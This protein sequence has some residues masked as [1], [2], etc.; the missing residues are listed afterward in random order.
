MIQY[1]Q[2]VEG[3]LWLPITVAIILAVM[4]S[5]EPAFDEN[6]GTFIHRCGLFL[7]LAFLL[8]P[9]MF[10]VLCMFAGIVLLAWKTYWWLRHGAW[11]PM[12][13]SDVLYVLDVRPW[14]TTGWAGID[15]VISDVLAWNALPFLLIGL[16]LA[17]LVL[18]GGII[19]LAAAIWNA[20]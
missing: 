12:E 17:T 8:T 4:T 11:L 5:F 14:K 16:P 15:Q 9:V 2:P 7:L 6:K 20:R 3:G 13:L 10:A 19:L 18:W 1:L